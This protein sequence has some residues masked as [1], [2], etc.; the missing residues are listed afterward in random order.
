M[1]NHSTFNFANPDDYINTTAFFSGIKKTILSK[2]FRGGII[3]NLFGETVIDFT[4]ADLTGVAVLD[5]T[6]GFGEV[7]IIVPQDWCIE[8]DTTKVLASVEDKRTNT[9]ESYNSSKILVIR[10]VSVFAAVKVLNRI[11]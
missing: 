5:I 6:Q 10:G 2:D 7:K 4:H 3:N 9:G 8:T 11:W 1:N